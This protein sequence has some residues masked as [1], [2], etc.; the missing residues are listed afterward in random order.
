[1]PP[2]SSQTRQLRPL[3]DRRDGVAYA[4]ALEAARKARRTLM[5][6]IPLTVAVAVL[7]AFRRQWLGQDTPVR[8]AAAVV[9]ILLGW[10]L[11]GNLA[12]MLVPRL[13][14]SLNP[15]SAESAAF[16]VRLLLLGAIVL[17]S[18]KISGVS[19]AGLVAG[20]S[21][22]AIVLGLAAQ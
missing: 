1:M 10:P 4:R 21:V 8:V 14:R 19:P 22:T 18:L 20:A 16:T 15:A 11:A 9:L 5:L 6:L 2:L 3:L 17:V 7:Y 13:T 12:R